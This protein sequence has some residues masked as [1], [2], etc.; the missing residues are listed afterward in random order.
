[1]QY[2]ERLYSYLCL[3]IDR[4]EEQQQKLM[5]CKQARQKHATKAATE[6]Y[7]KLTTPKEP[8]SYILA[9]VVV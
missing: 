5:Y 7:S 6:T 9:A 1:M 2:F 3:E 8:I 4:C